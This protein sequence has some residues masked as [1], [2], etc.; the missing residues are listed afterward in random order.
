MISAIPMP[1]R[2][3]LTFIL[4]MTL[5]PTRPPIPAQMALTQSVRGSI[6]MT[7]TVA[8]V[9]TVIVKI[10]QVFNVPGISLSGTALVN[11]NQAVS[12]P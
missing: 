8:T 5:E 1:Q 11:L 7:V 6:S 10:V 9:I 12:V 3:A 2:M 4:E